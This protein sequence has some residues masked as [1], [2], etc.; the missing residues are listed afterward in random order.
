LNHGRN[1]SSVCYISLDRRTATIE[2]LDAGA[3]LISALRV[4]V[5]IN[6]DIYTCLRQSYS[7]P[8]TDPSIS[9]CDQRNFS[10]TIIHKTIS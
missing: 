4:N 8:A 1:L 6:R 2:F 5:I 10:S 3:H 7:D 9:T